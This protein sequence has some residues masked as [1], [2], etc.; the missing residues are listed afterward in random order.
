MP[1]RGGCLAGSL[2]QG[3]EASRFRAC[4][5]HCRRAP[6]ITFKKAGVLTR[7]IESF[8]CKLHVSRP[9]ACGQFCREL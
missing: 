4:D 5:H 8:W 7:M 6:R 3:S 1:A 2:G 9:Y